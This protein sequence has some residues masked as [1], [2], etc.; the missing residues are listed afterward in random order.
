VGL[1]E[2]YRRGAVVAL[3]RTIDERVSELAAPEDGVLLTRRGRVGDVVGP[4]LVA[5]AKRP[6]SLLAGDPPGKRRE[7]SGSGEWLLAPDR[8]VLVECAATA[9]LVRIWSIPDGALLREFR[10]H[11]AQFGDAGPR[12]GRV[13]VHPKGAL[14]L[15]AWDRAGMFSV[16]DLRSGSCTGSFRDSSAPMNV[17]VNERDWRLSTEGEESGSAGRYR[18]T[19]ATVW[20]LETCLRL[21]RLTDD[22]QRRLGGFEHRSV[23]DCFG[24]AAFSPDGRFRAVPVMGRTGPTGISLRAA[25]SEQELFRAEHGPSARVRVAFSADGQFLLASR[26]SPQDSQ[27]DVWEL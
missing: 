6:A 14:T 9:E 26:E 23:N 8:R 25:V 4:T 15:V 1:G 12:R 3:V 5:A 10:P 19:V 27:V 17:L 16:W 24:E 21:E 22:W 7:L 11:L 20:D 13:F 18:R 2:A